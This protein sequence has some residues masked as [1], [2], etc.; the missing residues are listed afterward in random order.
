MWVSMSILNKNYLT[1]IYLTILLVIL[2]YVNLGLS[3]GIQIESPTNIK[4]DRSTNTLNLS[5]MTLRQK[6]AQM[7]VT[8]GKMAN[9]EILQNMVVGGIHLG[10][11]SSKQDFI[12][13]INY[14]QNNSVIPF[15]L[16]V[17]MEGCI[18]PFE[19]FQN[20]SSLKEIV[21]TQQA[22]QVGSDEGKMMKDL[23]MTI[24][25]SPVVDL[26][27]T[28]WNCRNFLGTP[29]EIADKAVAYI[30]GIQSQGIIATAKHYPGKTLTLADPH[31]SLVYATIDENDLLPFR[32]A[33]RNN[34]SAIMV[35]HVIANGSVDSQGKPSDASQQLVANLRANF[36]G[37]VVTDETSMLG[38]RNFYSNIDQV[39]V[40]VFKANNDL[41]LYININ[42]DPNNLYHAISVV[43]DAVNRGEISEKR[44][45]DSVTKILSIKGISVVT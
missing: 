14:F 24:D 29:Q 38:L 39:T 19:N 31:T 16:T 3:T 26:N 10:G 4:F 11:M 44:I 1:T 32:D 12:N 40:E 18:N 13:T 37:L 28:I 35:D 27:D 21:T 33:I 9:R 20:F 8:S 36:S 5:S 45:D 22:F 30:N 23:N 17:D 41:I 34:V 42:S 6:I 15:L 2:I 25:F 43:E 7:F